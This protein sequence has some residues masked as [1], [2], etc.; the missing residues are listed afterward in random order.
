MSAFL[1]RFCKQLLMVLIGFTGVITVSSALAVSTTGEAGDDQAKLHHISDGLYFLHDQVGTNSVFLV[2]DEGVLVIDSQPHPDS[3]RKL[4]DIIRD[5]TEK[6]VKYVIISQSHG[7]HYFGNSVFKEQGAQIISHRETAEVMAENFNYEV[8]QRTRR[9]TA[10]GFDIDEVALVMP[11]ITFEEKLTIQLGKRTV[12]L[13]HV[14]EGQN[15][16]DTLI[17][18]PHDQYVIYQLYR[19]LD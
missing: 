10:K 6:P 8:H 1:M 19:E 12:E 18:F 11:D 7:D 14:G 13:I 17:L 2:T 5:V 16:G 4:L 15:P 3:A 9:L